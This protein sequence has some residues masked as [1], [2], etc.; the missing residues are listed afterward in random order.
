MH[1]KKSLHKSLC[2]CYV[3]RGKVHRLL[4][5]VWDSLKETLFL[6]TEVNATGRSV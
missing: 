5:L 2:K 6:Q 1:L 4:A 3:E